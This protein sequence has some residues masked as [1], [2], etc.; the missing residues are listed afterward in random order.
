VGSSTHWF[1]V[2]VA[3][4]PQSKDEVQGVPGVGSG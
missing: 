3:R 2:Q 1:D 4:V